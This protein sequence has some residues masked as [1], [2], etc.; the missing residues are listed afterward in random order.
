MN[1]W[2]AEIN[3]NLANPLVVLFGNKTDL[4]KDKWQ[5]T[6]E[7]ASKFA[8]EKGIAYFE[9]SAKTKIG[10]NEGLSYIVNRV[11]NK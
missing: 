9:T 10:V 1:I 6:S 4:E 8:K 7:E 3:E 11:Y 2:L 5:V